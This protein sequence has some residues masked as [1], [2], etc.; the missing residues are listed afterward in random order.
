[1]Y[2][3]ARNTIEGFNGY[4]KDGSRE[5]M[6]QSS[7]RRLHGHTAQYFLVAVQIASANVRKILSFLASEAGETD[8]A[9]VSRDVP[10]K[11][12]SQAVK[13]NSVAPDLVRGEPPK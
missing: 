6:D 8:R 13:L 5:P 10:R 9:V 4:I 7:R 2:A 3:T 12:K 11:R 1:M